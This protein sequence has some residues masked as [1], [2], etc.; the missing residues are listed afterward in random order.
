MQNKKYQTVET[1]PK[2]NSQSY[3]EAK[4]MQN[5]HKY[6]TVQFPGLEKALQ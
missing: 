3:K 6:M 2:S 5:T 1:V 4:Y